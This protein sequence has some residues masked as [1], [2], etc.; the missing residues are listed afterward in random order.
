MKKLGVV[1]TDG[2]GYRNFVLSDFITEAHDAF[3]E[4]VIF[5]C[6]PKHVYDNLNIN[7]TVVEL[8][9]FKESFITWFFRK[10]KE[11]THL[12]VH[13]NDNYG[14]ADNLRANYS[15]SINPRGI[16]TRFIYTWVAR[17]HSE[18][19]VQRYNRI[20]Q[21][22]FHSHKI[23][24]KYKQLL[25]EH[26]ISMLFFTHQRPSYIAPLIYAAQQLK[27]KTTAF[28]FSWD[29]L[30]SKG[31]MAGDF[32]YYLVWS[33]LMKQELLH[34]YKAINETQVAVVGTPQ[35][36]PYVLSRYGMSKEAF[37][38][39]FQLDENLPTVLFSCGDVSTS[40]N[41]PLYISSIA[42]A[43]Q[44][45]QLTQKVNFLV[46]TSPAE[47]PARFAALVEKYPFIRWN[48]PAWSQT[49]SNHLESWS[50][51]IP[52]VADVTDLKAVLMYTD[53]SINMLSTMS[54]DN[55]LFDKPVIN[56]VFGNAENGLYN[57]QRFLKYAH[58]EKVVQSDAVA[59]VKDENAL[60]LAINKCL[61]T[62]KYKL[63]EQKALLAMQIG[64]PL[65]GTSKRIA[66]IIKKWS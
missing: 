46:R 60:L 23:T 20:Q 26:N 42:S 22:T 44:N 16:A 21:K 1:I 61:G 4:V 54:L 45:N 56:V 57:D 53:V 7:C 8:D 55:M 17:S 48:Y 33:D 65:E 35:F 34:F 18:K 3:D 14:I 6:L 5:S 52:S 11:V 36:E 39:R 29:N 51:R 19:W 13:A 27:I 47:E 49:R 59:I 12:K 37:T 62:P 63:N 50:Q 24:K 40:K 28:I 38:N 32:D 31:R 25:Q 58:I 41:D 66:T 10:A 9:V 64:M 30:A 15:A 2:V 43:I